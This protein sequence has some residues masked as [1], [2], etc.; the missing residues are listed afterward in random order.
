MAAILEVESTLTDRYQTTVPEM[1]RRVLGLGK[2][3][4]IRYEIGPNGEVVLARVE[5]S[6]ED[7]PVVEPF[8]EFLASDM[9]R[10]PER[11]MSLSA[12]LP[13]QLNSLIGDVDVDLDAPLPD[14]DE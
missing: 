11:L 5:V 13:S 6:R 14:G 3:D 2:R 12:A 8:L 1:V 9:A 7:D 4:R 10:H